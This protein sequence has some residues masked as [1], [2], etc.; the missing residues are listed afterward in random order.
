MRFSI[1][2][3]IFN[4]NTR[5]LSKNLAEDYFDIL[6]IVTRLLLFICK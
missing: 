3:Y 2:I 6:E 1:E 4:L 5:T